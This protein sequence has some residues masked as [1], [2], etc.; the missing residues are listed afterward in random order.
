MVALVAQAETKSCP[1]GK[2]LILGKCFDARPKGRAHDSQGM[3][4]LCAA[5]YQ[6][7]PKTRACEKQRPR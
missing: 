3:C 1:A 4:T 7:N 5:G 2:E 6:K